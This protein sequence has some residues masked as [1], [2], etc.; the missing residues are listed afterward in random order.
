MNVVVISIDNLRYDCVGYQGDKRELERHGVAGLLKTPTLDRL[1]EKS[2]C[3]TQCIS[4][5]TYTTASHAS[6]FTGMYPPNHGV[7]AFYGTKLGDVKT[8]A[9]RMREM[10]Y[11][12]ILYSDA[13]E[14][15]LPLGLQRGF[16]RVL[17]RNDQKLFDLLKNQGKE[18]VLLFC[19]FMDVHEPFMHCEYEYEA[20]VNDDF[21]EMVEAMVR[22]YGLLDGLEE[23]AARKALNWRGLIDK[24]LDQKPIGTMLPIYVKGV[25]KFD[26]GRFRYFLEGLSGIGF[27]ER[28]LIAVL[29][30]HG[31]GRCFETNESFLGHGGLLYDNVIRVPLMISHPDLAP[32]IEDKLVSTVDLAPTVLALLNQEWGGETN[33]IDLLSRNREIA[34]SEHWISSVDVPTFVARMKRSMR[35]QG[36]APEEEWPQYMLYQFSARTDTRKYV[37]FNRGNH[38]DFSRKEIYD[39]PNELFVI[40]LYRSILGRFEDRSELEHYTGLLD[41]GTRTRRDLVAGFL[42]S[43]EYRR[44]QTLSPRYSLFDLEEDPEEFAPNDVTDDLG[45]KP[46]FD[47][48][49]EA[50]A[51]PIETVE[52]FQEVAKEGMEKPEE[53]AAGEREV[54]MAKMKD[55]GY[56]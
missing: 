17:S 39:L 16:D 41:K 15:F 24:A 10:G 28:A 21:H 25:T 54:L 56:F 40:A 18:K 55:L 14:L 31:E 42:S 19:H 51:D 52:V 37:F 8:L 12:T 38:E 3:F 22:R 26:Q 29:A 11:E 30:D 46:Y 53:E 9:D 27:M 50:N 45:A 23:V 49:I 7:R 5:N 20:G 43:E 1:A 32:G 44:L 36:R 48:I 6:M 33:G 34:Y 47:H 2:R 35:D 4:T 13:P